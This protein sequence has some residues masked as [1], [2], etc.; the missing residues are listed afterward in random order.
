MAWG[1]LAAVIC[2]VFGKFVFV[3]N[4]KKYG[5]AAVPVVTALVVL[6]ILIYRHI[7]NEKEKKTY[8]N[9]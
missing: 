9:E 1:I 8:G 5:S 4:V 3:G 7:V 6:F 2:F